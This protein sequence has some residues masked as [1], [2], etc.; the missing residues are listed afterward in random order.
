MV[1]TGGEFTLAW[2]SLIV[3]CA[4]CL[5]AS[6][7]F[8]GCE[9]GYMSVS[10]IRLLHHRS[11]SDRRVATLLGH[12]TDM[13]DPILTC[14][15][16]TNL[17][18]VLT[19]ALMTAALTVLFGEILPKSLY[20]EY[21]E[22]L[23]VASIPLITVFMYT[24][25]PVRWLLLGYSALWRRILPAQETDQVGRLDRSRLTALLLSPAQSINGDARFQAT[26][27][28]FLELSTRDLR[29]IARPVADLVTVPADADLE[30]CL[31]IAASSG[32]SRLPV[33]GDDGLFAGY[34][35]VRDL[36]FLPESGQQTAERKD[37]DAETG[38]TVAETSG[39]PQRLVRSFLLV[40]EAM[41]PYELFEELH[42]QGT[43]L[44]LVVDRDGRP[45]GMVTLE[46]LIETVVGSIHDEFDN[47]RLPISA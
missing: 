14:L 2:E 16:G 36:L 23:T 21:P 10:R 22:R 1:G 41:S 30:Q 44:A 20:R 11:R 17:F 6:A 45:H 37:G 27:N 38:E 34:I 9:T 26:L 46:D 43:Q 12:L 19:T 4:V 3:V 7:F 24:V 15:I 32:F 40:D 5:A 8:S 33:V 13:E 29:S 25:A 31:H 35:L 28:R 47:T 42:G 39:I 18:N